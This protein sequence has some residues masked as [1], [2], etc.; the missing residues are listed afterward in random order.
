LLDSGLVTT[1]RSSNWTGRFP[2][3]SFRTRRS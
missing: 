1:P 3:S 2:A